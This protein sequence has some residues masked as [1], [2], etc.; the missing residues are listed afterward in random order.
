MSFF[1]L[2][3]FSCFRSLKLKQLNWIQLSCFFIITLM[4]S[5]WRLNNLSS[6]KKTLWDTICFACFL[7]NW[8][9][10]RQ[11]YWRQ[12][13]SWVAGTPTPPGL[14]RPSLTWET[15]TMTVTLVMTTPSLPDISAFILVKP[16][17]VH[18]IL[19]TL[20]LLIA[21]LAVIEEH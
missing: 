20:L 15:W 2:F 21:W 9:C 6:V 4:L 3:F 1:F 14:E 12:S 8:L 19:L 18:T 13:F 7:T 16:F 17:Q 10:L 11:I 5:L